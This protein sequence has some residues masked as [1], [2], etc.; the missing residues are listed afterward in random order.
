[1]AHYPSNGRNGRQGFSDRSPRAPSWKR[2][3]TQP[4]EYVSRNDP[5]PPKDPDEVKAPKRAELGFED[6]F[7]SVNTNF[8]SLVFFEADGSAV[9]KKG[10]D[11][12]LSLKPKGQATMVG[13]FRVENATF[14]GLDLKK[15]IMRYY[16]NGK[17]RVPRYVKI[18]QVHVD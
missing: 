10:S 8:G 12:Y 9:R 3:V 11:G 15:E 6:I 18:L 7:K 4:E 13:Y 1:M 16:A 14:D 2:P 5:L 17:G